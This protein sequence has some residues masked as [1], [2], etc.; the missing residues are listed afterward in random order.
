MRT[1]K[2]WFFVEGQTSAKSDPDSEL[3]SE[4]KDVLAGLSVPAMIASVAYAEGCRIRR[5]RLSDDAA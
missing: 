2:G 1:P 5:V 4:L 3:K